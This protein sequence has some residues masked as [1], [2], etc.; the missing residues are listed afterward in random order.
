MP[1]KPQTLEAKIVAKSRLFTVEQ[2]QLRF[3]NGVE[4]TYE[5]LVNK[6]QG[7]G[8]VMVVA[9]Q[10]ERPALLIEEYCGGTDD[11][12][13]SLPKG[14]VEPGED[15]LDAANRELMEEAGFGAQQLEFLTHLSLSPGYMSQKIA[16]VLARDLYEKRLPGDEPEPIRVDQVDLYQLSELTARANF[17]EGRA[18]AALYLVRDLLEQ[19]G[20]L[21]R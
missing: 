9:M 21:Q 8:A 20:E 18:L 2:V 17:T 6:G 13:L 7:Y 15:V 16:V 3:S 1:Q 14:L 10:D 4:R 19:R 12:Q 5:R 11:Y